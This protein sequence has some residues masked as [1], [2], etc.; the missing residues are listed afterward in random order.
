MRASLRPKYKGWINLIARAIRTLGFEYVSDK[1]PLPGV[2][3]E[4]ERLPTGWIL[5]G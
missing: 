4:K 1:L 5:D 2:L 3:V